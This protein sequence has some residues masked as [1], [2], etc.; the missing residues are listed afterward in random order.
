MLSQIRKDEILIFTMYL[1]GIAFFLQFILLYLIQI[2]IK[3][4][5]FQWIVKENLK[6]LFYYLSFIGVV[7]RMR[8]NV[9][10]PD[11][12]VGN[13]FSLRNWRVVLKIMGWINFNIWYRR[14]FIF[15]SLSFFILSFY[16]ALGIELIF[17]ERE[18]KIYF[19][20]GLVLLL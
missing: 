13:D 2:S 17:Q 5:C 11:W 7:L 20:W 9:F 1:L 6:C 16:M 14:K 3:N 8:T 19:W 18:Y 12:M 15:W 10:I 4:L